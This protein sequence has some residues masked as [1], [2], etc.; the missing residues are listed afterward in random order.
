MGKSIYI[1]R[2]RV[3]TRQGCGRRRFWEYDYLP[4]D[5]LI[6]TTDG[7]IVGGIT[8]TT[9]S[10]PLLNG[11]AIHATHARLLAGMSIDDAVAQ[12]QTE[13]TTEVCSKGVF[14]EMDVPGLIKEQIA[15]LEGMAR[16]WAKWRLPVILEEYELAQFDGQPAIEQSWEWEMAPG[17]VQRLRMDAILRRREDGLLHILDYK[18]A[19]YVSEGWRDKFEH[20]LQTELY[21]QALKERTGEPVGGMLYEGLIKG[22]YAKDGAQKSK[23]FGQKIQQTPYCFA[24][25]LEG[26]EGKVWSASYT[27]KK[28]FEK[29]RITDH[30]TT[31]RWIEDVLKYQVQPSDMFVVTPPVCPPPYELERVKK[32]VVQ[33][34]LAY[35]TNLDLYRELLAEGQDDQAL[36]LLDRFAPQ[37]GGMCYRFGIDYK[38]PFV[39][40]VCWSQ[41][42]RPLEDGGFEPRTPHHEP[43]SEVA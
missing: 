5:Q 6:P 37:I 15:M 27:A 10:L 9:G 26:A 11:I 12:T 3:A 36:D 23:F 43:T 35:H 2:S 7:E 19:A 18:S 4:D 34:E 39:T 8:R 24:Y 41:G 38:C 28:G 14:G 13:Y 1:D 30:M 33:Q 25:L 31:E 20:D 40:D 29:V 32:Q 17:L 22:K 16:L 42:A 21:V